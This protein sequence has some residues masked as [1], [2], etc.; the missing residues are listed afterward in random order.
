MTPEE[1]KHDQVSLRN[2]SAVRFTAL[3]LLMILPSLLLGGPA[4][5]KFLLPASI[6][7]GLWIAILIY[8][9]E[10]AS[11]FAAGAAFLIMV[12]SYYLSDNVYADGP[13]LCH[14]L[15]WLSVFFIVAAIP[16]TFFREEILKHCGLDGASMK[17]SHETPP[18]P[19]DSLP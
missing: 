10:T 3:V 1:T 2:I 7:G 4:S 12:G 9:W 16:I 8:H 18:A 17:T 15:Q 19:S 6:A 5:W 11:Q 13:S 14:F